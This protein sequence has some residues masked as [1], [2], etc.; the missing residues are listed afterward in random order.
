MNY[1][2]H[3]RLFLDRPYF[4]AGTAIP[5]WLSVIDRRIRVRTKHAQPLIPDHDAVTSELAAGVVQHHADDRWFHQ[6]RAFAELSLEFSATIRDTLPPDNG[7]RPSFLGHIL[8]E[9]LLDDVLVAEAPE[10]LDAYYDALMTIDGQT[11]AAFVER[12]TGKS[13]DG[14]NKF[15]QLFLKARFLYDYADNGKLLY[16]LNNVMKRV[17]LSSIPNDMLSILPGLRSIV[18]KR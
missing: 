4:L 11:V 18:R 7:L 16:R 9:I 17:G 12:A 6:T 13:A 15:I 3:G 2:T 8:V 1:F 5:D 14:M 10:K